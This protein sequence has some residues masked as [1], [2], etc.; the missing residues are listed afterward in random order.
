MRFGNVVV[1]GMGTAASVAA[2]C[3]NS[4]LAQAP[5]LLG[6]RIAA[7]AVAPNPNSVLSALVTFRAEQADS[8]RVLFAGRNLPLD[9][10]PY[11]KVHPGTDT[12]PILGLRPTATYHQLVQ[13]IG[14]S[15]ATSSD[16]VFYPTGAPPALLQHLAITA[17]GPGGPGL[18]LSAAQVGGDAVAAFP[19]DSGA[20]IR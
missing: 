8:A 16:T 1:L 17:A 20:M 9:S 10:T 6:P 11:F 5:S 7:I 19:F 18:T 3:D 15:G 2:G 12:I 13:V 4:D 14:P